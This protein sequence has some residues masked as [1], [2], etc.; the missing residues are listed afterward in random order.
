MVMTVEERLASQ[1]GLLVLQLAQAHKQIE[2]LSVP[3]EAPPAQ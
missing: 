1:I 2:E 3:K